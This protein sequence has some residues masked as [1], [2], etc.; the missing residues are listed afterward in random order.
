MCFIILLVLDF[1]NFI[2]Y[3]LLFAGENFA[4]PCTGCRVNATL[5]SA[6]RWT[7]ATRSCA[8][9]WPRARMATGRPRSAPRK[10]SC[11]RTSGER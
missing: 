3:K 1:L 11:G 8:L 7:E 9:P 2:F 5:S 10:E 6:N 4:T